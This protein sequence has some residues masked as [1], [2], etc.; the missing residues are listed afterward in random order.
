MTDYRRLNLR[1]VH[2]PEERFERAD[3]D[4]ILVVEWNGGGSSLVAASHGFKMDVQFLRARRDRVINQ[5]NQR[6]QFMSYND[7]PFFLLGGAARS[8]DEVVKFR[9]AYRLHRP[10]YAVL[11][12]P[13]GV[14]MSDGQYDCMRRIDSTMYGE[15]LGSIWKVG[16]LGK[17]A[18]EMFGGPSV[19]HFAKTMGCRYSECGLLAVCDGRGIIQHQPMQFS[20]GLEVAI[21]DEKRQKRYSANSGVGVL[22]LQTVRSPGPKWPLVVGAGG[23]VREIS[24]TENA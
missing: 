4:N 10:K 16:V 9:Q 7:G 5:M 22:I 6:Y 19:M 2:I 23:E 20:R 13:L 18:L 12:T 24:T 1:E 14:D 21:T 17:D 15:I 3:G 8:E 11:S